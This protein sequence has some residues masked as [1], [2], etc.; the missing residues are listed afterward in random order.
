MTI[1]LEGG[2][3]SL[4]SRTEAGRTPDW[5][6]ST[7]SSFRKNSILVSILGGAEVDI[8]WTDP[9]FWVARVHRC[10]NFTVSNGGFSRCSTGKRPYLAKFS[11]QSVVRQ[12]LVKLNHELCFAAIKNY[13]GRHHR[14]IETVHTEDKRATGGSKPCPQPKGMLRPHAIASN[15]IPGNGS[16]AAAPTKCQ[17][18]PLRIRLG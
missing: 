2:S 9:D 6:R 16:K 8:R 18:V 3:L 10:D 11:G 1:A 7:V 5:Y 17:K 4:L 14:R 15:R 12:I 13:A